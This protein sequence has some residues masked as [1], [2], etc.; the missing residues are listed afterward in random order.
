MIFERCSCVSGIQQSM[1]GFKTIPIP[2]TH[3][4]LKRDI[5]RRPV[6]FVCFDPCPSVVI[7]TKVFL[8]CVLRLRRVLRKMVGPYGCSMETSWP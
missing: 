7:Q 3:P 2:S 4:V 5:R 6:P 8:N 1:F